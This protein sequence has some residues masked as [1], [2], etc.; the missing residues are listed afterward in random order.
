MNQGRL[1]LLVWVTLPFDCDL[2]NFR[3]ASAGGLCYMGAKQASEA[4]LWLATKCGCGGMVDAPDLGSG[5]ARRGGSSP[6]TRTIIYKD[7]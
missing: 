7:D 5:A 2:R 6:L 4:T 3:L 1:G